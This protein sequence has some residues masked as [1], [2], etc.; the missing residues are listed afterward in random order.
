[1][2][3]KIQG[4][5][6]VKLL[7]Y[8]AISFKQFGCF[9]FGRVNIVKIETTCGPVNPGLHIKEKIIKQQKKHMI[10]K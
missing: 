9:L 3:S 1:M 6:R 10:T 8:G 4:G 2:K 5:T 7:I